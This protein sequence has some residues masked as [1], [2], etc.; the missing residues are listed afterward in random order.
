MIQRS[1]IYIAVLFAA[2]CIEGQRADESMKVVDGS[3]SS[4]LTPP[5]AINAKGIRVSGQHACFHLNGR[6]KCWGVNSMGTLGLGHNRN[7]GDNTDEMDHLPDVNIG[8][9]IVDVFLDN[10][11]TCA[12]KANG[13]LV[14][15]G[16]RG[17]NPF[18]CMTGVSFFASLRLRYWGDDPNEITPQLS[19]GIQ[20]GNGISDFKEL[21]MASSSCV[22]LPNNQLKC[23]GGNY[24]GEL[25]YEYKVPLGSPTITKYFFV[26]NNPPVALGNGVYAVKVATGVAHSCAV[27]NSGRIKCWGENAFV[28]PSFGTIFP[29]GALGTESL[30]SYGDRPGTMGDNL[31][32]V[33]LGSSQTASDVK[34][35]GVATCALLHSK[36]VKCWGLNGSGILGQGDTDTRG[37]SP[38]TMGD[39][40][41]PIDLG[42]GVAVSAI[43]LG[44]DHACA[45]LDTGKIKCW[46]GNQVGQ[47]GYGDRINRGDDPG[48]MGDHLP[49]VDLGDAYKAI[50][51]STAGYFTCALLSD[52]SVKCWGSNS[53]GELGQGHTNNIG[54]DPGEM[55][56]RLKAI[57]F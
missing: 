9:D 39:N 37:A 13:E 31:P 8:S 10:R 23:F 27:L 56:E 52:D 26:K 16:D 48:E 45:L 5:S 44:E 35:N 49:I 3:Q 15:W 53:F 6:L 36:E 32:T 46:G 12:K 33:D 51:I 34:A 50:Q 38:G 4:P 40:L 18:S 7:I 19:S 1:M 47:L 29:I 57:K 24:R 43:A 30:A 11:T 28:N 54:D 22:I 17:V 42:S 21:S 25:G 14:C 2:G 20:W 55:G 41:P